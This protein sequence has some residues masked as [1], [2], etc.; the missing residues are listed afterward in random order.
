[1]SPMTLRILHY[2]LFGALCLMDVVSAAQ[3]QAGLQLCNQSTGA[4]TGAPRCRNLS[5]MCKG[6][7]SDTAYPD[8]CHPYIMWSG[9]PKSDGVYW[10]PSLGG[11]VISLTDACFTGYCSGTY[12]FTVR[13]VLGY[14]LK[15]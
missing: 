14:E 8:V 15:F 13:C 7:M 5:G 1:M 11:G 9:T 3:M 6:S 10:A 12:A 2:C 4:S